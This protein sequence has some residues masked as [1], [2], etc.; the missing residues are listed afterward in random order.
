[1]GLAVFPGD[2][3]AYWTRY[4]V[5]G[6]RGGPP[7]SFDNRSILAFWLRRG[8]DQPWPMI[9]AGACGV[10]VAIVAFRHAT[11]LFKAGHAARAAILV[12]CLGGPWT[13]VRL[14]VFSRRADGA[15]S[16]MR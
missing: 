9:L 4:L 2:S 5:D 15:G 8:L 7:A 12:G 3:V 1:M 13:P 14:V 11:Q 10:L 6:L 16:G